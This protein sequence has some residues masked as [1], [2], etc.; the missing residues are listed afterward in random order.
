MLDKILKLR[1]QLFVLRSKA[2]KNFIIVPNSINNGLI[3][4]SLL[5][6]QVFPGFDDS[7]KIG[8]KGLGNGLRLKSASL[9]HREWREN[10]P[11]EKVGLNGTVRKF[12]KSL[13]VE[14]IHRQLLDE[15][16]Q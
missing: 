15:T 2:R 14:L 13:S 9:R 10:G 12:W 16:T 3:E 4:N 1:A 8:F 5:P 7:G 11:P 6:F